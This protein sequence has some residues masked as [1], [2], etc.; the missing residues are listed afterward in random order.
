M[1][2]TRSG[3]SSKTQTRIIPGNQISPP[4]NKLPQN[5]GSHV[6]VLRVRRTH[7]VLCQVL[8]PL[9]MLENR[10][11]RHTKPG[12]KIIHTYRENI[13]IF[14]VSARTNGI[15][16]YGGTDSNRHSH[17]LEKS[18]H[19]TSLFLTSMHNIGAIHISSK[20]GVSSRDQT[21]HNQRVSGTIL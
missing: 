2:S 6:D 14:M 9:V 19:S 17:Q 5:G 18:N 8:R 7:W 3:G 16:Q 4:K 13:T 15:L 11:V 1:C 12:D 20:H 21:T 10:N